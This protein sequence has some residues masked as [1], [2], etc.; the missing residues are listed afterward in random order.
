MVGEVRAVESW[1]YLVFII[2]L[3]DLFPVWVDMG[4]PRLHLRAN[5]F[6]HD[7]LH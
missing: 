6:K 7:V 2:A 1:Y 3:A 5:I 4:S